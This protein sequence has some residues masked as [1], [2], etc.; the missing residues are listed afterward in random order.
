[1]TKDD[2]ANTQEPEGDP[3][4]RVRQPQRFQRLGA[5]SE[6]LDASDHYVCKPKSL[7]HHIRDRYATC[8]RVAAELD[9]RAHSVA[10]VAD[11]GDVGDEVVRP[12]LKEALEEALK[13]V[14]ASALSL[15]LN[16]AMGR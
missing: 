3:A 15:S 2:A 16:A 4:T 8:S 1:M 7:E 11:T 10:I 12:R 9:S 5:A 14:H 6:V 13:L